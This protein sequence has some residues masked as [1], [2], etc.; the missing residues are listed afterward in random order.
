MTELQ[1][2][3][4]GPVDVVLLSPRRALRHGT[5]TFTIEFR[6][7]SVGTLVDAGDVRVSANMPMPGMAMFGNVDVRRTAVAGRY[8]A[9]ARFDMAGTW[10]MTISWGGPGEQGS[11]S[12]TGAVQ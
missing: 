10:R 9:D 1:R 5:D 3:S 11:V 6:S 4:S 2:V 12:I 8:A 7:T